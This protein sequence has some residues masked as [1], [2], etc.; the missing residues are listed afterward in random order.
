[1]KKKI[2]LDVDTGVDDAVGIILAIKSDQ[3]DI[4][5]ITTVSGNVSLDTATK[6]TC[7]VVDLVDAK[8][9]SIVK[10]A[11]SP[12]LRRPFF[13][14]RIHGEDGLGG[15]LKNTVVTKQA[16]EGFAADFIVH[17]IL[18]NPGEVTLVCTGPL[19]NLALALKKCPN[20]AGLVKKV[21]FM[22]GV[23]FDCGNVTPAAEY[24]MYVDPEAAKIV[25]YAG[26]RELTQVGLNVT[27]KVLLTDAH[28]KRIKNQKLQDFVQACTDDYQQ[29][30]YER[31]GILGCAMH[32]PLAVA[33]AIEKSLVKT[34]H[35]YVDI[36]TNS[37]LCDGQLI[38][39]KQNRLS[40]TKNIKVCTEVD[41]EAFFEMFIR[42]MN[43]S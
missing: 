27:R 40:K 18:S 17:S 32:D 38:C 37:S 39:D 34:E 6:N 19:T 43:A 24:N 25:F 35:Y 36:E 16:D 30:Y 9:I 23:I 28:I 26:F 14:H 2:I 13:E 7:K 5:G 10:G 15:A 11:S 21:I 41:A 12:L 29:R 4:L 22:G 42:M 1:M 8:S 31:H 20:I 33:V 3:F